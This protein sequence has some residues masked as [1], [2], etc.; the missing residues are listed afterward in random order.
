MCSSLSE[1]FCYKKF[2]LVTSEILRPFLN[3]LTLDDKY[4]LRN[5]ENLTLAI[6]MQLSKRQQIFFNFFTAFLK[7][8]FDFGHF[9]KKDYPPSLCISKVIDWE[10]SGT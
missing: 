4:S 7:S 10:R 2:F 9:G 3:L 5:R 6:Q 8:T 1:N